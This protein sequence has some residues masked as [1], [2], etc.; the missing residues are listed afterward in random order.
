MRAPWD[1]RQRR[2]S[3]SRRTRR[4]VSSR[5]GF[6]REFDEAIALPNGRDDPMV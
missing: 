6:G 2:Y 3:F 5:A 1:V 4:Q